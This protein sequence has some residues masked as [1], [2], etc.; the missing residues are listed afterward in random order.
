MTSGTS[1][2][3]GANLEILVVGAGIAGLGAARALRKRGF[4]PDVVEQERTWAD[5]GA[6][7]YLPGNAAR[8]LRALGLQSA[9]AERGSLIPYQRLCD[10]RGR[11]LADIDMAALWG[12]VG[13][14]LAV[15]RSDL[16]QV[17][18]FHGQPVPIRM[19]RQA[20]RLSQHDNTVT[21]EFADGT[22]D[23]YDLVIGADGIHS[24]TRQLTVDAR[25]IRPVGQLAWRFVTECPPDVTTW[26]AMLGRDVT[27]LAVPIGRGRVYCYCDAPTD[28]IPQLQGSDV[29][30]QLAEMLSGFAA[31][32]PAI[33][34]ALGPNGTVHLAPIEE[35]SLDRWSDGSVL[36][37][38]DAAHATSPNMAEG[39][40]MALEDG[41]VLAE[42][43]ASEPD[44]AQAMARFQARRRP[45]TE[46]VL[47]QTHRR[48]RT[49][50]LPPAVRNLLL[51]RS[52]RNIFRANYR[53][54]LGLP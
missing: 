18:A 2:N 6:G 25:A 10:H 3:I 51:R 32:V 7:I 17:L 50:N 29:T 15:H 30:S 14:C 4:A 16:H 20:R 13:P 48:D 31:P 54:L 24:T 49:R 41:L 28:G 42:S 35:V 39:A 12:D 43:L 44:I 8:A 26:T 22:A 37:V 11:L 1:G 53:P 27:F 33:L 9:V 45:R 47:A 36:L 19:G 23:N 40:A 21:V 5:P 34:E 46:W 38:G 52:G